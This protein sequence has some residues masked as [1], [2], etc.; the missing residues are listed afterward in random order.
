MTADGAD[1][2]LK[3]VSLKPRGPNSVA[4]AKPHA[5]SEIGTLLASDY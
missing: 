3:R 5:A 2:P 1:A 4:H